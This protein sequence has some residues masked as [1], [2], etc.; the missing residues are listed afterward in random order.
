MKWLYRIG[1]YNG[2]IYRI[3]PVT[4]TV[5]F[6]SPTQGVWRDSASFLSKHTAS[7][8]MRPISAS[9]VRY[10]EANGGYTEIPTK[11]YSQKIV[12]LPA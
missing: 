12:N 4:L 9:V 1:N 8:G 7:V 6:L 11:Q 2:M 10:F 3:N 5:Q